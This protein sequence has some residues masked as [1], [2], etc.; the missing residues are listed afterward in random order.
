M[1]P[2][3]YECYIYSYRLLFFPFNIFYYQNHFQKNNSS[4]IRADTITSPASDTPVLPIPAIR[5]MAGINNLPT[6]GKIPRKTV[7]SRQIARKRKQIWRR[8]EWLTAATHVFSRDL[9][10]MPGW[11]FYTGKYVIFGLI[12]RDTLS[13]YYCYEYK[14]LCWYWC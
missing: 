5:E 11:T 2:K 8:C 4:L 12:R 13:C 7:V 14:L 10:K 1:S 3:I 6:S 9:K